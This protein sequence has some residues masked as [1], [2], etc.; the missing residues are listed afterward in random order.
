MSVYFDD[1][2]NLTSD[3]A[4]GFGADELV[5]SFERIAEAR[6]QKQMEA[7]RQAVEEGRRIEPRRPRIGYGGEL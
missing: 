5:S 6:L 1:N 4:E 7:T 2:G 3:L